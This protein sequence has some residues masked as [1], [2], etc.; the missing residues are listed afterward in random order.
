MVPRKKIKKILISSGLAGI[1]LV[2]IMVI[3]PQYW[4]AYSCRSVCSSAES[5][6]NYIASMI[7]DYFSIPEHKFVKAADLDRLI[8]TENLWTIHQC[9]NVIYIYVYDLNEDCP[10]EY[11]NSK[12]EW[13]SSIYTKIMDD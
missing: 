1:A 5:D 8:Q 3:S 2:V 13:N 7:A 6:A 9:G 10:I 4:P 12:P 11:Q